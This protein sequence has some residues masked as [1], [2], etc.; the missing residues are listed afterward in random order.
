M[1][2]FT[3]LF[4]PLFRFLIWS[5]KLMPHCVK[6]LI[7]TQHVLSLIIALILCKR[8]KMFDQDHRTLPLLFFFFPNIVPQRSNCIQNGFFHSLYTYCFLCSVALETSVGSFILPS[9]R[10]KNERQE[11][12]FPNLYHVSCLL[13]IGLFFLQMLQVFW[14]LGI[15]LPQSPLDCG[16]G[17]LSGCYLPSI[18]Y[19]LPTCFL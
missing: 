9:S 8:P 13:L 4:I 5:P 2:Q 19:T 12:N 10:Y 1:F 6:F 3:S 16:N 17:S 11:H 14:V 15:A 7:Q 18:P